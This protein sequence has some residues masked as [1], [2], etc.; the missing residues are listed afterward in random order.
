MRELKL[1]KSRKLAYSHI[2][3][4]LK[5][6]G[7]TAENVKKKKTLTLNHQTA[8]HMNIHKSNTP[9]CGVYQIIL[10]SGSVTLCAEK[11]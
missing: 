7:G 6:Y 10:V 1:E 5:N 9:V 2:A 8:V 4:E 3:R 11:K